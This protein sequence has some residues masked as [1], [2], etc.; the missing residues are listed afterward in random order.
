SSAIPSPRAPILFDVAVG[1]SLT[2]GLAQVELLDVPMALQ[3]FAISIEDDAPV[4]HHIGVVGDLQCCGRALFDQ[5][6]SDAEFVTYGLQATGEALHNKRSQ[7][8]RQLSHET[9]CRY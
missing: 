5:Q 7:A 2:G 6:D 4:L 3:P 1:A 9:K 8:E